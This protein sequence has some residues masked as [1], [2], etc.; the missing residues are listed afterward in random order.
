MKLYFTKSDKNDCIQFQSTHSDTRFSKKKQN[1]NYF[2]ELNLTV[3]IVKASFNVAGRLD[4]IL[5]SNSHAGS[6]SC[7]C[8]NHNAMLQAVLIPFSAQS[9][10]VTAPLAIAIL[11]DSPATLL[12]LPRQLHGW[13][14]VFFIFYPFCLFIS[15]FNIFCLLIPL[16]ERIPVCLTITKR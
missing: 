10:M 5:C 2:R 14:K 9:A 4:S 7:H 12:N 6:S 13:K 3:A 15:F 11:P 8:L 16:S 1:Q